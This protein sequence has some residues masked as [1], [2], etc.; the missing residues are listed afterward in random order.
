MKSIKKIVLFILT[1]L[2]LITVTACRVDYTEYNPDSSTVID[3]LSDSHRLV[4]GTSTGDTTENVVEK[5]TT[6]G[7]VNIFAK[8]STN[9]A[10]KIAG[11]EDGISFAFK[12]V[13]ASK[14]FK[15][16]ADIKVVLFGGIGTSGETTSNGQ[17]GF[18][19]MARDYI[20]QYPGTTI[21][22]LLTSDTYRAGSTGGSGNMVMAGGI[23][24]G[25]RAAVRTG[26][27]G[28]TDVI[29]DSNVIS[30]AS[31]SLFEYWPAELADYSPY[32]TLNERPDFPLMDG[33]YRISMEK[34]NNGFII[35]IT[36]PAEKGSTQ[37]YFIPE[38]ENLTVIEKEK[39][40]VG[41]FA[42]R[43]AEIVVSNISYSESNRADDAPWIEP[44]PEII[45]PEFAIVSPST[46]SD[47][48]YK[49]YARS[50]VEGYL[51]VKQNGVIVPGAEYV[52]GTLITE[53]SSSAVEPFTLFDIPV[54]PLEAGDNVFQVTFHPK[55]S[56]EI[57]NN[58]SISETFIV[59]RRSYHNGINNIYVSP[60]GRS[61]N[62]G[63]ESDP[64]DLNTA[65]NFVAPDQTIV[66]KNGEYN[67]L[68]LEIPR[69]NN[70]KFGRLKRIVAEETDK[71][72]IDFQ[73][74]ISSTG[75][76]LRGN[77]WELNGIHIRNT[78]DKRKG[79]QVM[80]NN[81][82]IHR[83]KTYNNGD[84]GLQISGSKAEPKSMWPSNNLVEYCE[85]YNNKDAAQTDA[86]GFA[87]KLTV[88][89]GN[90][91]SWCIS[92][93]NGDDGWDL[94]TKKETG[95]I[96]VVTIENCI[97]YQNGLLMDGVQTLAGRNGFKLGGEGLSVPHVITNSL[98]FQ[99]GAHGFT[100]N[101]NP[102]IQLTN[103]TSYDNG[104]VF[105]VKNGADSR[106]FTIY[107]AS[108]VTE[109]L[110]AELE[111]LLSLFSNPLVDGEYRKVD[112]ISLKVPSDGF[113]W[114]GTATIDKNN[115]ELTVSDVISTTIPLWNEDF[116]EV[117]TEGPGFIKRDENGE[118]IIGD[119][120]KLKPEITYSAG[121]VFN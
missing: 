90:K 113:A 33:T 60:T 32:P 10:G 91:F 28:G 107:N 24:R 92:H 82:L 119:F 88:G 15:L 112:K 108:N 7:T 66:M 18:G 23:K 61:F 21:Q 121:S 25:V 76:V 115:N 42:A 27:T 13:D 35:I 17:E 56:D 102:G 117:V 109:N 46:N 3:F 50:N 73:K 26:V 40:Y 41:F 85:S 39:Y 11:S 99:N 70:G 30:D 87:A 104:G 83:V 49:L 103:V 6:L 81:N 44:L 89:N 52:E 57:S 20:P 111:G 95:T 4:F 118:F 79:L 16:S 8:N 51:S 59:E 22:D 101:S 14:N 31:K 106:N 74:N 38:P 53:P 98:S 110:T 58:S 68:S 12:E 71:V 97:T 1:C 72:F 96:G 45:T 105:N 94:F 67:F 93:N 114:S 86:D 5:D 36:P 116:S 29:V 63:T 65:I 80:G 43:S 84:T 62:S 75:A 77:Y 55:N 2:L 120:M 19:L 100:S 69:Y 37:E 78:R 54:Y 48:D 34:N 64:L 47:D 9:N